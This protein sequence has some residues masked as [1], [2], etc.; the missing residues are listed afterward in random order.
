[1]AYIAHF[2]PA[3]GHDTA[4]VSIRDD[5]GIPAIDLE[6]PGDI[7]QPQ[8]AGD[9]LRTNGW[10]P[11]ADWTSASDGWTVPVVPA[12]APRSSPPV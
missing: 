7:A 4:T 2:T 3:R 1:M 9:A 8:Q 11:T 10:K 5:R 12:S 6:L